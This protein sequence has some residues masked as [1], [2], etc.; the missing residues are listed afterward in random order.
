MRF[1][2]HRGSLALDFVGTVG[3]RASAS[4]EERLPDPDALGAWL[5]EAGLLEGAV[6]PTVRE[7]AG[8]RALREAAWRTLAAAMTRTAPSRADITA[9]NRAAR[10]LREGAPRLTTTLETHW[11]TDRPVAFA[12]A[13]VASDAI[14]VAARE[15]ERLARCELPGCGALL[16][17]RSRGETRK[18]C[19]MVTCGNRAKVAAFRERRRREASR[20]SKPGRARVASPRTSRGAGPRQVAS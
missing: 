3:R 9:L 14:H 20:P 6:A 4:P 7:L 17:S 19:S 10:G 11:D 5:L 12:L 15:A 2:F 1:T 13:R 16:L 8:A 18:W